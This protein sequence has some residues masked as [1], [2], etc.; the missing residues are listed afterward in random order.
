MKKK[1]KK[2]RMKEEVPFTQLSSEV[3]EG[4]HR[5]EL[6][7]HPRIPLQGHLGLLTFGVVH[8]GVPDGPLQS[9]DTS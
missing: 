3:R 6:L 2:K 1:K 4:D 7:L 9:F 5:V 8:N